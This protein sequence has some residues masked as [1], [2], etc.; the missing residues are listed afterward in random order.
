MAVLTNNR[1]IYDNICQILSYIWWLLVNT[2]IYG[3]NAKYRQEF[4]EI[5]TK[6]MTN[7]E[8]IHIS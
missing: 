2:A 1:Q 4:S 5:S 7:Y 8:N 6:L 3:Q